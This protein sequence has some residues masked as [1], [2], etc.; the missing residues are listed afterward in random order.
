MLEE[1]DNFI[2]ENVKSKKKGTPLIRNPGNQGHH[3]NN[4]YKKN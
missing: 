3:E 1:M 4:K 2:K